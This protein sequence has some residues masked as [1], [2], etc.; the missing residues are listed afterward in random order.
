M[1]YEFLKLFQQIEFDMDSEGPMLLE[2]Y[3]DLPGQGMALRHSQTLNTEATTPGRLPVNIRLPG[4]CKGR[5]MKLRVSGGYICRIFGARVFAKDLGT[6]APTSWSWRPV[7]VD[8]TP[9]DFT[10]VKL[11]IDPT[12]PDF[13]T[14]K[15]PIDGTPLDFSVV[16]VPLE[17]SDVLFQW[18]DVPVDAVE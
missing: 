4:S 9:D 10:T 16:K 11:P 1:A 5:A 17:D 2:V 18:V 13:A 12:P 6:P 7:P 3:T 8:V 14:V 15:L